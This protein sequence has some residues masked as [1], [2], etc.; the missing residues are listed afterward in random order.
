MTA[1]IARW[2]LIALTLA[3]LAIWLPQV[4]ALLFEYR[5][6]KTQLF[7]SP[8][9]ERFV[10]KELLG[11]GHQFVYR[12][13]DGRDYS[14]E[15]FEQLIPFIYYKNMEL[16]GQLP[17]ELAGQRF[18]KAAIRAERLVLEFEPRDLPARAPRIQLFPLLESNPG[19]SRLRFPENIMRP[20][21]A[22][23]FIDS[24]A[25]RRDPTLTATFTRALDDAGFVFPVRAT[26]GRVS[27]LKAFDAGYFLLDDTGALFQL[28]RVDGA[29][30]V[31]LVPLPE[32]LKVRA[33]KISE[34]TGSAH[35]GFLLAED[36]QLYLLGRDDDPLIPLELPAFD[37]ERMELKILFNPLYRTAI[38][39]DRQDIHAVAMQRD[40]TPIAH[41]QRRMAMA[42][43]RLVD[44][45][46]DSLTP[47]S[48]QWRLPESRYL[49]LRLCWHGAK[50][51]IGSGLALVLAL[52]WLRWRRAP[53]LANRAFLALVVLTG[54][55]GLIA[56]LLFPPEE[57]VSQ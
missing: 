44:T 55:M 14:R 51:C 26:F 32:G 38:Y 1:R 18:D 25:N 41:Y 39:S 31:R 34:N 23:T 13:Q 48:L 36:G 57:N 7:Y 19:R 52:A 45:L 8:V 5:F 22:L 43:P 29:P 21:Q 56:F 54:F 35:L 50:A 17:L 42:E 33:L 37:P 47:F 10:Y 20:G 12:D 24:D 49:Q 53:L 30:W 27:I 16:W 40:F 28:K 11:T 6:G 3:L 15:E 46:W 9:I 4:K 2:S